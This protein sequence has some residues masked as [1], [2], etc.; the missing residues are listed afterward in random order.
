M[1]TTRTAGLI[2]MAVGGGLALVGGALTGLHVSER[3]R[4][5]YYSTSSIPVRSHG[6]AV[7]SA[8]L[9]LEGIDGAL[10][11][12]IAGKVRVRVDPDGGAPVFVGIA[13]KRDVDRYLGGV[14]RTVV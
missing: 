1:S 4:D 2:G 13:A 8:K 6:Y 12:D 3:D 7:T 9:G 11:R 14:A 5:G 10:A